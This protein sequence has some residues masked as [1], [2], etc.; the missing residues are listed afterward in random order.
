MM[1][2]KRDKKHPVEDITVASATGPSSIISGG[3]SRN[4]IQRCSLQPNGANPLR[5]SHLT[6]ITKC[7]T[8]ALTP[9]NVAQP[10]W[11]GDV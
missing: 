4:P 3:S 2:L 9:R 8:R 11:S 1:Q 7:L 5:K 10:L 6:T